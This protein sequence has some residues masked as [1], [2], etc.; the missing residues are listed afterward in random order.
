MNILITK[1][2]YVFRFASFWFNLLMRVVAPVSIIAWKFGVF[3][4]E[5]EPKVRVRG[6]ILV[7]LV[8]SVLISKKEILEFA[9]EL[10]NKGW[11][12]SVR[13]T[14]IWVAAF[15]MVWFTNVFI[16]QMLWVIGAFTVGTAQ[17]L[18]T[19]PIHNHYKNKI[20]LANKKE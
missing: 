5:V 1:K 2:D 16:E 11:Y 17:S 14:L 9:K 10:E 13:S 6:I 4:V 19:L 7:S 3:E 18:I 20:K 15:L 12:K 8:F